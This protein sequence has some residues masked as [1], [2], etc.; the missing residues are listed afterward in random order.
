SCLAGHSWPY[1]WYDS[2]ILAFDL[3]IAPGFGYS[4]EAA[5][6]A[7]T[8]WP[9]PEKMKKIG[10]PAEVPRQVVPQFE[11][12]PPR[13][14]RYVVSLYPQVT[15]Q[16]SNG[17]VSSLGGTVSLTASGTNSPASIVFIVDSTTNCTLIEHLN[18]DFSFAGFS[19]GVL[20]VS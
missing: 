17:I 1:Q 2:T 20:S 10:R 5:L 6:L 19:N 14:P 16:S 7:H 13:V 8:K 9:P 3:V 12:I 18:F 11:D 4:K 15:P